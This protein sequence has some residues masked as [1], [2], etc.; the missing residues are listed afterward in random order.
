LQVP[1]SL[2]RTATDEDPSV[3]DPAERVRRF[4]QDDHV[5]LYARDYYER[6]AEAGLNVELWDAFTNDPERARAWNLNRQEK[7]TVAKRL[8]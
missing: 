5:R 2:V 4:G 1:I 7:L 3:T 8:S 6:L